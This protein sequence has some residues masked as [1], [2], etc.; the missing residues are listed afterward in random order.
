M[1]KRINALK[2]FVSI[3]IVLSFFSSCGEQQN[4][5]IVID[6]PADLRMK[7][8]PQEAADFAWK[9]FLAISKFDSNGLGTKWEN[10]KEAY[11]IF[12]PEA[13]QPSPWGDTSAI[14]A[15]LC[16][17]SFRG[18]ILRTTSKVSPIINETAQAVGGALI[19]RNSNLVHYEVYMNQPMFQYVLDS[20]FYDAVKQAGSNINFPIGSMEIKAA[21]R[22]LDSSLDDI[23]RYHTAK[24]IIYLPDSIKGL[25]EDCLPEIVMKGVQNCSE[26]LVGLVGLHIVYKTPSNPHFTWITFE[27]IDNVDSHDV[28]GHHIPASFRNKK[29]AKPYCPDNSRQCDCP[30]QESSQITRQDSLKDWVKTI[31]KTKQDSLHT[32]NSIWQYYQLI[33]IQWAMDSSRTGNPILANLANTSMETFNQTASSCIGCHAFSRSTNPTVLSD[34]SWVMGRAQNPKPKLPDTTGAAILRY[35]MREKPYKKWG[36][37]KK[38]IWIDTT[39]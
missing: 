14:N 38:T 10:Y 31:N 21:W 3:F 8:T 17:S 2:I 16:G 22:I 13:K 28:D 30:D 27:Q 9:T 24:A 1:K 7:A 34:F 5:E 25:R 11:D 35:I 19:D 15:L 6:L 23:S 26:Q 18:K 32:A 33:G 36:T 20:Q 29:K 12:L 39:Q 37:W 4:T